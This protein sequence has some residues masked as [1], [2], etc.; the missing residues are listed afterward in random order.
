MAKVIVYDAVSYT[1]LSQ[2]TFRSG[3]PHTN[4]LVTQSLA[5]RLGK[6]S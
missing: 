1:Q 6:T 4:A 3:L 2:P 5:V